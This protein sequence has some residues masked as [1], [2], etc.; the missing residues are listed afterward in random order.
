MLVRRIFVIIPDAGMISSDD[1][2]AAPHIFP[3]DRGKNGF[4]GPAVTR[5]SR[6][7]AERHV[8]VRVKPKIH[9]D[10]IALDHGFRQEI[11]LFAWADHG[12]DVKS[13]RM[14]KLQ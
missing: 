7:T 8:F 4:A 3:A 6:E 11:P 12:V 2:M 5:I 1:K 9:H 10:L 13:V 14:A